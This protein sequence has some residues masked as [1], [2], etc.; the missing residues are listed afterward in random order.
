VLTG[1]SKKRIKVT[2]KSRVM[3]DLIQRVSITGVTTNI[4]IFVTSIVKYSCK[5]G[6]FIGFTELMEHPTISVGGP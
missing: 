4:N 5:T 2:G 1:I 6:N 3:F